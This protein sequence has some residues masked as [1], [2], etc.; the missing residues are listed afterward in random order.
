MKVRLYDT[1]LDAL[2]AAREKAIKDNRKI[3]IYT[4]A[5]GSYFISEDHLSTNIGEAYPGGRVVWKGGS[6]TDER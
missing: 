3:Y 6:L 2:E 4:H 5:F 1:P